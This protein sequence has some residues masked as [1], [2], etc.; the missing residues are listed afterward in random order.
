MTAG[1]QYP[2]RLTVPPRQAPLPVC[3]MDSAADIAFGPLFPQDTCRC[4]APGWP[5]NTIGS[6]VFMCEYWHTVRKA[7]TPSSVGVGSS[8]VF[9]MRSTADP[10][11]PGGILAGS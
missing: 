6:S 7:L 5:G 11:T 1:A 4:D 10:G 8:P 9:V 2:V 3:A